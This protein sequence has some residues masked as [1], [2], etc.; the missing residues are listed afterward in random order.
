VF[1][2]DLSA[3]QVPLDFY[4]ENE[5]VFF[6]L[7]HNTYDESKL[8]C[9]KA[10]PATTELF[11]DVFGQHPN[12]KNLMKFFAV[13]VVKFL[14]ENGFKLCREFQAWKASFQSHSR[15][16]QAKMFKYMAAVSSYAGFDVMKF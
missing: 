15:A 3:Y 9:M 8:A 6:K 1:F 2:T 12:K 14:W 13:D 5:G 7:I 10:K 11:K 16:E 4:L